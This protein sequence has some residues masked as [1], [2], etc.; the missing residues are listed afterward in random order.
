M[1][2]AFFVHALEC[3][4]KA[5]SWVW[6]N[7]SLLLACWSCAWLNAHC[8]H[9]IH[10]HLLLTLL[11]LILRILRHRHHLLWH[12]HHTTLSWMISGICCELVVHSFPTTSSTSPSS[13]TH[14]RIHHHL[15]G[16]PLHS[17]WKVPR[18]PRHK[19]LYEN[20]SSSVPSSGLW[21]H[22]ARG[23]R[24]RIHTLHC[25]LFLIFV[26]ELP[27]PF[28]STLSKRDVEKFP[29]NHFAMHVSHRFRGSLRCRIVYESKPSRHPILKL[30]CR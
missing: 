11:H 26:L 24:T 22:V 19:W 15:V 25:C 29:V 23:R 30:H 4:G 18:T 2:L 7:L 1:L 21:I 12:R 6:L 10:H 16:H 9:L 27:Q 28:I 17:L 5:G 20:W 14:A 8:G 13:S 3:G